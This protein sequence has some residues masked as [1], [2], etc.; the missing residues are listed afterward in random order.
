MFVFYSVRKIIGYTACSILS[1]IAYIYTFRNHD[2]KKNNKNEI[3]R[4]N[5]MPF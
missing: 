2:K 3:K 1:Q 5:Y 4:R